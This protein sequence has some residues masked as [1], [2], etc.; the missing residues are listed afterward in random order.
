MDQINQLSIQ[1]GK[2][3]A[4]RFILKEKIDYDPFIAISD[5][6]LV[7]KTVPISFDSFRTTIS[8]LDPALWAA[9]AKSVELLAADH[10]ESFS[11]DDYA[12][13]FAEGVAAVWEKIRDRVL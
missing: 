12:I 2:E 11:A 6:H 7:R 4:E 9:I 5:L 3:D 1:L 10:G 13:G 8:D